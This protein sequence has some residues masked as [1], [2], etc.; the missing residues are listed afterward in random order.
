VCAAVLLLSCSGSS[1]GPPPDSPLAPAPPRAA[2]DGLPPALAAVQ[3]LALEQSYRAEVQVSSEGGEKIEGRFE[4]AAPDRY[5][6]FIEGGIPIE[7]ITIG[8][9]SYVKSGGRWQQAEPTFLPFSVHDLLV[10]LASMAAGE[11]SGPGSQEGCLAYDGPNAG[12]ICIDSHQR[13]SSA[14]V[15]DGLTTASLRFVDFG[16]RVEIKR[17]I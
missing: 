4:F 14:Q 9:V 8:P 11:P 2:L 6:V 5:H 16:S 10:E 13:V 1:A 12:E 15:R 17:P 3:G 7:V